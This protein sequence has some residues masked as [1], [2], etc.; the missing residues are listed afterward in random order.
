MKNFDKNMTLAFYFFFFRG[1]VVVEDSIGLSLGVTRIGHG[2]SYSGKAI[3]RGEDYIY[4]L[5]RVEHFCW[6]CFPL[7]RSRTND[8]IKPKFA[9]SMVDYELNHS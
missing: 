6:L 7:R 9:D 4:V 8:V 2:F 3:T 1:H 5:R